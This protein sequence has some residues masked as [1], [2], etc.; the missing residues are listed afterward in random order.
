MDELAEIRQHLLQ[1]S[2]D[3]LIVVDDRGRICFVNDTV[4]SLLGYQPSELLG[5]P[6][7][8]LIPERLRERHAGHL[9]HF[10]RAPESR[11]MA[12]RATDL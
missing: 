4:A 2:P 12:A 3:A 11:E 10:M 1:F 6:V 7:E 8:I 9:S 5:R